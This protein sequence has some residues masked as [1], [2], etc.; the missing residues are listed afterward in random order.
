MVFFCFPEHI[1]L[2]PRLSFHRAL[3]KTTVGTEHFQWYESWVLLASAADSGNLSSPHHLVG[4][5]KPCMQELLHS[6]L[7]N[8]LIYKI[9]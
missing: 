7:S 6:Y 8:E 3:P 4:G 9:W 5:T 2:L 1:S